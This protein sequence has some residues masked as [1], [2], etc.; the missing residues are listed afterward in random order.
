MYQPKTRTK[1]NLSF[2]KD[3]RQS[4][5]SVFWDPQHCLYLLGLVENKG[6]LG[7]EQCL[8][9]CTYAQTYWYLK[10]SLPL[11]HSRNVAELQQER[12]EA[13][14]LRASLL[15]SHTPSP[16]IYTSISIPIS[17][18]LSLSPCDFMMALK[19]AYA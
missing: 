10:D 11:A 7:S 13:H 17:L 4:E 14:G 15:L 16:S 18:S 3:R 12:R 5:E 9:V 1:D 19:K 8:E 6:I 2:E